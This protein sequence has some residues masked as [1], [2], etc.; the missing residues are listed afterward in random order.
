MLMDKEERYR[1]KRKGREIFIMKLKKITTSI[2]ILGMVSVAAAGCGNAQSEDIT[3]VSREDGSGTRGAFVEL[4]N[5]EKEQD[6]EKVDLTTE[7]AQITNSTSVVLI[8]VK[9]DEYAIG[10]ISLGSL[11]DSVKALQIDGVSAS[12]ETVKDGSYKIARPFQVVIKEDI[13][14]PA[15]D[16][17]MN[18]ILSTEGQSVVEAN[19]YIASEEGTGYAANNASGKI[20]VGGSSSVSPVMEKLIEVYKGVNPNV[21]FELQTTDSTTGITETISGNYDLGIASRELKDTETSSGIKA[22]VIAIDGI[23][24]IVNQD[25]AVD[26]LSS[27]QVKGIYTGEILTWNE[28]ED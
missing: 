5:V 3:V 24:V 13:Q 4:F 27:D 8:T 14:N 18:F 19:G 12:A 2:I 28:V 15:V 26:G 20:V 23:A 21:Q 22:T 9:E 16:D 6:G 1:I 25:N 11:N 17:F 7:E 10:Y